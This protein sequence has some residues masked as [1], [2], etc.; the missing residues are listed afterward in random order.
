MGQ[1]LPE[2]P[3]KEGAFGL[4]NEGSGKGREKWGFS[5]VQME[6]CEGG[7]VAMGAQPARVSRHLKQIEIVSHFLP[8][9]WWLQGRDEFRR[10][11]RGSAAP[12][13]DGNGKQQP[14]SGSS[15]N[16]RVETRR[17]IWAGP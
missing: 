2:N 11:P 12:T 8:M 4:R 6:G 5:R 3:F 13:N 1:K 10:P 17:R 7:R 14:P 9:T 16:R 15:A